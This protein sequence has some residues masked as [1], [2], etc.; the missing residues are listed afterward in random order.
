MN[1]LFLCCQCFWVWNKFFVSVIFVSYCHLFL[2]TKFF[3]SYRFLFPI[4]VSQWIFL[5]LDTEFFVSHSRFTMDFCFPVLFLN[6]FLFLNTK[7][8]VSYWIPCF[9]V[10][11]VFD[12]KTN[13]LT[14]KQL[15]L[16]RKQNTF[17]PETSIFDKCTVVSGSW[18]L[19]YKKTRTALGMPRINSPRVSRRARA[20]QLYEL[21]MPP[22]MHIISSW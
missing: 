16:I 2:N 19:Y 18:F 14:W 20:T 11:I 22:G 21:V 1:F 10:T 6:G 4:L 7:C 8:F 5:F 3:V 15:I 12:S 17:D 13:V 9:F